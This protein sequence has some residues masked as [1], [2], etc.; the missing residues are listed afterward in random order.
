M[1]WGSYIDS[2]S[3]PE[4][5][6]HKEQTDYSIRGMGEEKVK[7]LL[8]TDMGLFGQSQCVDS[9]EAQAWTKDC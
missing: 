9:E 7:T 5:S 2:L 4:L 6:Y 1:V 8:L 3:C